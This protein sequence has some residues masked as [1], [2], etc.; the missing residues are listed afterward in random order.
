MSKKITRRDFLKGLG[1]AGVGVAGMSLLGC[2]STTAAT[3]TSEESKD[4]AI[5]V[6]GTYTAKASGIGEVTVTMTFTATAISD[7]TIDTSNETDGYGLDKGDTLAEQV[8]AAQGSNIDG[9]S[10][11]TLTSDAVRKAVDDCISQALIIKEEAVAAATTWRDGPGY[12]VSDDEISETYDCDVLVVGMGY[13]GIAATRAAAEAGANVIGLES[14]IQ[15]DYWCVG[16]DMGHINSKKLL[17]AGV[18]E[19]DPVEF[20]NNWQ[21][22]TH[23]K[24]NPAL[25]MQFAKNSGDTVDWILDACPSEITD[26]LHISFWPETDNAIHQLN[27]GYRYYVGT[28][29]AWEWGWTHDGDVGNNTPGYIEMKDLMNSNLDYIAENYANAQVQFGVHGEYLI[30]NGDAV[31]GMIAVTADGNYIKYNAKKVILT[32]GGFEGNSELLNDLLPTVKGMIT[33]NGEVKGGMFGGRDGSG[34]KMG[35]WAGGRLET[36]IST[37]NFDSTYTNNPDGH[38]TMIVDKEGNRFCNEG[39]GGPEIGG[40]PAARMK[41]GRIINI[42]DADV[43]NNITYTLSG[44]GCFEPQ[45]SYNVTN[46]MNNLNAAYEA[47][48]ASESGYFAADTLEEL[49]DYLGFDDTQKENFLNTVETYNNYCDEGVD[50]DFGKDPRLLFPIKKAPFYAHEMNANR[51]GMGLVTTGGFVTT[52]D[53]QIVD[54]NYEPIEGL[55]CAGNTCGLRFGPAYVTPIAGVSIGM[56]LTLGRLC[57]KH[58]AETL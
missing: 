31:T 9:V 50:G 53:Q 49:A 33:D 27:N 57:G 12:E 40:F 54:D 6:P 55:Y 4:G 34:H 42:F 43:E 19:V 51:V 3:E 22:M 1:A 13:A 23:N 25:V 16:H 35:V 47:G 45:Q 8:M 10:G 44:H 24:S 52:N 58:C 17:E 37:M 14:R 20:V 29:Q 41:R 7:I 18:P 39:F 21:L 26:K 46:L 56:A 5:Y 48:A 36:E 30:K 28:L 15:D 11:A 32:T 2:T 38:V